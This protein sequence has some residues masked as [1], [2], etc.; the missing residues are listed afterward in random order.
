MFSTQVLHLLQAQN[1]VFPRYFSSEIYPAGE[2]LVNNH[3]EEA[4]FSDHP[5]D[6][7]AD[8]NWAQTPI[9]LLPPHHC[10]SDTLT[11]L[12]TLTAEDGTTPSAYPLSPFFLGYHFKWNRK[13]KAALSR[14]YMD[15]TPIKAK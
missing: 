4:P 6:T 1:Q 15:T 11:R 7:P 8:D 13:F 3:N 10:P 5:G 12:N 2:G 9:F 14:P